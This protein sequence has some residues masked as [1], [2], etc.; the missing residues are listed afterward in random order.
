MVGARRSD[1]VMGLHAVENVAAASSR[2]RTGGRGNYAIA[3]RSSARPAVL[4]R[5]RGQGSSWGIRRS[6]DGSSQRGRVCARSDP[7]WSGG[8]WEIV[9]SGERIVA[10]GQRHENSGQWSVVSG[11]KMRREVT[12]G[13]RKASEQR[14]GSTTGVS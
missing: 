12:G 13:D 14:H 4:G 1:A 3:I 7:R 2:S 6:V 9:A 5:R 8:R 10:S 11:K